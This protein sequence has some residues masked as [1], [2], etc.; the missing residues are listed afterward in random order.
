MD[1]SNRLLEVFGNDPLELFV[2]DKHDD[3]PRTN[4]HKC[5]DEPVSTPAQHRH[6]TE[7]MTSQFLTATR[8][9]HIANAQYCSTE[10]R[11][12]FANLYYCKTPIFCS[13]FI[14]QI[15][16]P[17]SLH[18]NNRSRIIHISIILNK[19][20]RYREEHSASIVLSWCTL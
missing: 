8:I 11:T 1:K 3:V 7:I 9:M 19:K 14:S 16:L 15:L 13:S 2:C 12:T 5:R 18:E 10:Y 17:G 6:T 20:L 4:P